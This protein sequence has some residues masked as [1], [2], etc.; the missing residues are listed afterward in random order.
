M[1]NAFRD[2]EAA[3]DAILATDCGRS[4]SLTPLDAYARSRVDHTEPIYRLGQQVASF[5]PSPTLTQLLL[6]LRDNQDGTEAFIGTLA[7]TIPAAAFF[8]DENK[9]AIIANA[10]TQ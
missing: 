2:A 5:R 10:F 8:S 3:A 7:G 1:S 4:S 9:E 6:A